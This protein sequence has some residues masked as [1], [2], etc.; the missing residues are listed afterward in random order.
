[1]LHS[2]VFR[3]FETC[4]YAAKARRTQ[5]TSRYPLRCY[6]IVE[7]RDESDLARELPCQVCR[8]LPRQLSNLSLSLSSLAQG[9]QPAQ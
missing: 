5:R 2:K 8:G 6:K 9:T 4:G 7:L 3:A 1:M